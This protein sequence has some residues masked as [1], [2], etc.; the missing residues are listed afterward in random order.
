MAKNPGRITRAEKIASQ[1]LTEDYRTP[2][3]IGAEDAVLEK[4]VSRG[5]AEALLGN[6]SMT[7]RALVVDE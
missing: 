7:Y 2:S 5:V 4:L 6:G 1:K 3:A